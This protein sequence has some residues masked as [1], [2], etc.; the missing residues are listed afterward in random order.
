MWYFPLSAILVEGFKAEWTLNWFV[1]V[2][3]YEAISAPK[4][5][6]SLNPFS[7]ENIFNVILVGYDFIDFWHGPVLKY[8]FESVCLLFGSC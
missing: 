5:Q 4:N 2:T 6:A 7:G 3:P 1:F 8:V